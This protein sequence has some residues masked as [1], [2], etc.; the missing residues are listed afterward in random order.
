MLLLVGLGNPGRK[1]ARNRH[2]AGFMAL[3]AIRSR[4]QF[5]RTRKRFHG[6]CAE[7]LVDGVKL[8]ALEPMTYM[9]DSGVSVA[10]A[11]RFHKIPNS[12]VIVIHDELDLAVGKLRVKRGG[13]NAGHN[14]LHSIDS[15]LGKDYRRVRIGVGHPGRRNAVSGYVLRDFTKADLVVIDPILAATAEAFPFLVAGDDSGFMNKVALMTAPPKPAAPKMPDAAA[16]TRA[17][18]EPG[19]GV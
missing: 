19:N 13:G 1:Y 10:E 7:G 11:A 14:G 5:G 8:I 6:L 4:H 3:D 17:R 2:N 9:N 18:P 16:P 12:D 15:H